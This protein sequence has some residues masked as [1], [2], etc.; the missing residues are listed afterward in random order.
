MQV[1]SFPSLISAKRVRAINDP[2]PR[3]FEGQLA[4]YY[5]LP[6]P[7]F[8]QINDSKPPLYPV[9]AKIYGIAQ[10]LSADIAKLVYAAS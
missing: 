9:H 1:G 3:I 10:V 4:T 5:V 8:S 7:K 2:V 6:R